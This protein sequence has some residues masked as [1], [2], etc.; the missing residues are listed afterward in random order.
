MRLLPIASAILLVTAASVAF[1]Q[2]IFSATPNWVSTDVAGYATG[3]ALADINGDGWPDFVVSNGNDMARQRIAVYYNDGAGHFPGSPSW[4]STDIGYHGHLDVAD[5]NGDGWPDVAVAVLLNQGG[6]CAKLYM[7]NAGSLSLTP[8][9]TSTFI[10]PAFTLAFGDFNNDGRP[11]LA[12]GTGDSYSSTPHIYKNVIHMNVAGGLETTPSWQS[13]DTWC[14]DS[15]ICLDADN[16]GWLDLLGIGS[17]TYN[18]L[19]LNNAGALNT[20]A[21]WHTTDVASPFG[22][23]A[24][25]G[26][27]NADGRLDVVLA[28]NNQLTGGSGR[29]RRYDGQPAGPLAQSANWTYSDGYCSAVALAD[30]DADGDLDLATGAWWDNT[31][32]FYN[33][34][35]AFAAA[36]N[37]NTS[38]TSVVEKISFGDIDRDG[39]IA[40]TEQFAGPRQ[41]NYLRRQ[42]VE[43]VQAVRVDGV[44]LTQ[45]QYYVNREHGWFTVGVAP[46]SQV[47]IDYT[48]S[49]RLDMA[50]AN[51]DNTLGNYVFY[52]QR[53]CPPDLDGS[54][55]I[56]LADVAMILSHYGE[57]GTV[58]TPGDL[59]LDGDVDLSDLSQL[60]AL[61]GQACS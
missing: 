30:I 58:G 42:P 23:M 53:S 48:F 52:N 49:A 19:Y 7:N 47:E 2:T 29:F 18:W 34:G 10:A 27:L 22:L 59:D 45:S 17:K 1:S 50:I 6:A 35:G 41:L 28:D 36:S 37:W 16:D 14:Y 43:S 61:Y 39:L 55:V 54:H 25:A 24:A 21:T 9:W 13:A 46:T 31:R 33:T 20:T 38:G 60:L 56:D 26:D 12:V 57:S 4:Q 5:V 15:L 3:G 40:A 11:D 51:W 8:S 32:I 44:P